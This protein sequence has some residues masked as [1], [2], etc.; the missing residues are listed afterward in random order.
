MDPK[1]MTW[2]TLGSNFMMESPIVRLAG[3][4]FA[5]DADALTLVDV[6]GDA[7]DGDDVGVL[8]AELGPRPSI[9]STW[10]VTDHVP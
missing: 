10:A 3:A 8:Q 2:P 9:W 6:E 1:P 7:V 4:R 5:D